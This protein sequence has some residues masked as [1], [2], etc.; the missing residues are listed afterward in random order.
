MDIRKEVPRSTQRK[1]AHYLP[2][3]EKTSQ[4]M[5][6]LPL[7]QKKKERL[8]KQRTE[9]R[10]KGTRA[11]NSQR[12]FITVKWSL[13]ESHLAGRGKPNRSTQER[14]GKGGDGRPPHDPGKEK[15][16][17]DVC[18][19]QTGK[20]GEYLPVRKKTRR[21]SREGKANPF[22]EKEEGK[23]TSSVLCRKKR[24][25]WPARFKRKRH[26][27]PR[28]GISSKPEGAALGGGEDV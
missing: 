22:V 12:F 10:E 2:H 28:R 6:G 13:Q 25:R 9:G 21:P 24:K 20:P 4:K 16:I 14:G 27:K 26:H 23:G 15:E 5:K 11:I 7:V 3:I 1:G 19:Q 18:S 8:V 17:P